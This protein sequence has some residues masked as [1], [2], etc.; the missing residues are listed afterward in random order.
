MTAR[1]AYPYLLTP[2]PLTI[3]ARTKEAMLR[4][5]GSWDS[6]FNQITGRICERLVGIVNGAESHV[7][8]PL[9]AAARSRWRPRSGR[10][11]RAR[12]MCSSR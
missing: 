4:D 9:Q 10:W 11:C 12:V 5:W 1:P 2:G 3:S 8:V 7:C 6:E